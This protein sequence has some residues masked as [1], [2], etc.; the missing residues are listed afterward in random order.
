MKNHGKQFSGSLKRTDSGN[1]IPSP[2]GEGMGEGSKPQVCR[3]NIARSSNPEQNQ[4]TAFSGSP[5][6][7]KACSAQTKVQA[8]FAPSEPI[9]KS[10]KRFSGSLSADKPNPPPVFR[11][12]PKAACTPGCPFLP[13]HTETS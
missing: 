13:T 4:A 3:F 10:E 1:P 7:A 12:T 6:A 11:Q 9:E 2:V 8:A 5:N